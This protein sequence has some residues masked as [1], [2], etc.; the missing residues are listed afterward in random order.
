M[1]NSTN[2]KVKPPSTKVINKGIL[3]FTIFTIIGLIFI[4]WWKTPAGINHILDHLE[5]S[6]LLIFIPLIAL[7]YLIGGFRYSLFFDGKILPKISLWNCMRSNWANIFMG[8][9]TPF[10]TGGGPAQFYILWRNGAK[11]SQ[12]VLVSLINFSAT[13]TF[14]QIA[15]LLA[16]FIIPSTL[17]SQNFTYLMRTGF[18]VIFLL[19]GLMINILIFPKI[20]YRLIRFIFNLLPLKFFKLY[21]FRNRLLNTLDQEV[22]HFQD[23]FRNI[24]K[25]KKHYLFIIVT[26]TILLFFNKYIIGYFIAIS[27]STGIDFD[28]FIGLQIIQ[29]FLIYFAPTP[30]A[31]GLAEM[32][33]TW[34]MQTIMSG[35][36]LVFFVIIYRFFTT[37]LGAI[38][39]GAILLLDL[40]NWAKSSTK[41]DL[42]RSGITETS[43]IH[44]SGALDTISKKE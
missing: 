33:S 42:D 37:I 24:L 2:E 12:A 23:V 21:N 11:I 13:L 44:S 6:T 17:F 4:V 32:S 3:G 30:G 31:S 28:I 8:A 7:D 43:I 27:L 14:F 26:V 20:G 38:I 40:R 25:K 1:K 22:E 5:I 35:E 36:L 29:Y 41:N 15:S 34:L 9:V 39:G 16:I 10:Q 19:T 18:I